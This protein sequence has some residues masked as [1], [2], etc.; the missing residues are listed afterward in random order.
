MRSLESIHADVLAFLKKRAS[1]AVPSPETDL[2]E[3]GVLDSLVLIDLLVFLEEEY[4]V[5]LPVDKL[6]IDQV[7]SVARISSLIEQND[8]GIAPH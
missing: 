2:I 1:V 8:K 6:E 7:R 4:G 5:R 3:A